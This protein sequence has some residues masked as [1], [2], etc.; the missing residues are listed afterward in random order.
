MEKIVVVLIII[1]IVIYLFCI[2]CSLF[3]W[4]DLNTV[5][6]SLS[7]SNKYLL[8]KYNFNPSMVV[9]NVQTKLFSYNITTY[10]G[11]ERI[12][13]IYRSSNFPTKSKNSMVFIE[14][15]VYNYNF[16][17]T[18]KQYALTSDEYKEDPRL[19]VGDSG[20][21]LYIAFTTSIVDSNDFP[22]T[23]KQSISKLHWTHSDLSD[24]KMG[25]IQ[26]MENVPGN[27]NYTTWEK[28]W[29]F[30]E[31]N[32]NLFAV[33]S[34]TPFIIYKIN[35]YNDFTEIVNEN[36]TNDI[37]LRG[38]CPPL[39]IND[40]YYMVCHTPTYIPFIIA[41][42]KDTLRLSKISKNK[43]CHNC[44]GDTIYFPCGCLYDLQSD[45]LILSSGIDD[46]SI[47]IDRFKMNTLIYV[48]VNQ[49]IK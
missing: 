14:L 15:D 22:I 2:I 11:S 39:L 8:N 32:H 35:N 5:K 33:Y 10:D 18:D 17:N 37:V 12:C 40:M 6:T 48:N 23:Q 25:D 19:I 7:F 46:K 38:S 24:I 4:I 1:I 36:W 29:G 34:V 16:V 9:Y 27:E 21:Q 31:K 44:H 28:N 41:F 30:F 3:L 13:M 20:K 42:D 43:L 26:T 49:K 45:E 47:R